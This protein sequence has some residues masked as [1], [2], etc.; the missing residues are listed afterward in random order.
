MGIEY[1]CERCRAWVFNSALAYPPP[2]G[3]CLRCSF[4]ETTIP[5]PIERQEVRDYLDR[6]MSED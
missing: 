5:D 2:H 1:T 6:D 3:L 4:L